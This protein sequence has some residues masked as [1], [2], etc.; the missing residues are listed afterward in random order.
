VCDSMCVKGCNETERECVC[1]RKVCVCERE[2]MYVLSYGKGG[3]GT[4]LSGACFI[5]TLYDKT[6]FRPY[7]SLS[8]M[9]PT[10]LTG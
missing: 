6:S 4:N 3:K 9:M 7:K 2:D 5:S 8:Y 1:K 10:Q